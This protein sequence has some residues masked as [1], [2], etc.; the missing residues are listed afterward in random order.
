MQHVR[1]VDLGLELL[2]ESRR[3]V[4]DVRAA[5]GAPIRGRD[6]LAHRETG[7]RTRTAS[8]HSDVSVRDRLVSSEGRSV[9]LRQTS[10]AKPPEAGYLH[11]HGGGWVFG[12]AAIHDAE[13]A[14]LAHALGIAVFSVDYRLAPEDPFPAALDDAETAARWLTSE[15]AD[16]LGLRRLAIGGASAGA[17]LAAIALQRL[18]V[19]GATSKFC[20]A[21]LDYG[22]YD[23]SMTPSQR[24]ANDAPRMS[25]ADL[26]W[27]YEQVMPGSETLDRRSATVSPLY[28]DLRGMPPARFAVGTLD[29]LFDDS[30][31]MAARW[32]E[33][34]SPATLE[35]YLEGTHGLS[36]QANGLGTLARR[37]EAE[38]LAD[39]LET[40]PVRTSNDQ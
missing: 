31:L 2:D 11:F 34:G 39:H 20:A 36:R 25:R 13:L 28:G 8:A 29:A 23:L 21:T 15:G 3:F 12:A 22:I 38:F 7:L 40:R 32:A 10:P 14:D 24:A 26:E 1:R 19:D 4:A 6:I 18:A 9:R 30:V 33:A 37:R 16:E 27:F 35:V 5:A 17:H